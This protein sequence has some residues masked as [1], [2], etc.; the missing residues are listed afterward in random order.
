MLKPL[1]DRPATM[2]EALVEL[3]LL[4]QE[5]EFLRQQLEVAQTFQ[6]KM[7]L[8]LNKITINDL[9]EKKLLECRARELARTS[10]YSYI[11]GKYYFLIFCK[12]YGL[13]YADEV[14]QD[15]TLEFWEW[16][17]V[18]PGIKGY[19]LSNYSRIHM[20]KSIKATFQYAE[21]RNSI[22]RN[23]FKNRVLPH[24][25]IND[26]WTDE[27]YEELIQAIRTHVRPFYQHRYETIV[28]CLYTTGLRV[29]LFLGA[30]HSGVR[31]TED[32][33]VY[34]TTKRKVPKSSAIQEFTCE[35]FNEKAK[36]MYRE[37]YREGA[38]GYV[39]INNKTTPKGA[40][41]SFMTTLK[42]ACKK[43]GIPFKTPHKAK[44]GF[45][46]KMLLNG[47]TAEQICKMTGNLTPSLINKV[48]NHI[49]ASDFREQVK[50]DI[51]DI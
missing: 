14:T 3:R 49:Q 35:L 22:I 11:I 18:T 19:I 42:R 20:Q 1:D 23:P 5:N 25:P 34:I 47:Y 31:I 16:L 12:K 40:Y 46:T 39:L 27:Y 43:A 8:T 29:G 45:I 13:E 48:Y 10:I 7:G 41:D 28:R 17:K 37:Y 38:E 15:H 2:E 24:S 9:F 36:E 51:A 50:A 6:A 32:G 30:K 26:W 4:R 44:H 33:R 21:E